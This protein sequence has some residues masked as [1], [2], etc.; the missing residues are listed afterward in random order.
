MKLLGFL[1]L[2]VIGLSGSALSPSLATQS[3]SGDADDPAIWIHPSDSSKSLIIGTDKVSAAEG[4]GLYVFGLDG[5][6]RQAP[7]FLENPNNVDVEQGVRMSDGKT[8]DLAVATERGRRRLAIFTIDRSSGQLQNAT[9]KTA[10]FVKSKG[11]QRA[12]MGISLYKR[13]RDGALF[14]VVS[15]KEGPTSGYLHQYRIVRSETGRFDLRFVREFGFCKPGGEIEAL[16]VDDEMGFLYAAEEM[17]GIRKYAADPN[18]SNPNQELTVFGRSGFAEDREGLGLYRTG[19]GKG[20]ILCSDQ[21]KG[22]S[23]LRVFPREGSAHPE[24]AAI[25]T[26]ADATDGIEVTA[27][28]LGPQFPKGVVSMMDSKR[29]RFVLFAWEKVAAAGN[30]GRR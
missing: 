24:L 7:H 21:R 23:Y 4:G 26:M 25:P 9:G 20:Y 22:G 19:P 17:F 1:F 30:L 29:K 13:P 16:L 11:E 3:V 2:A 15:R 27:A 8:Y 10:V 12:P 18:G 28:E 6:L 14:A 5:E